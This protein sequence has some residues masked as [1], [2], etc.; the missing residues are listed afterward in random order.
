MAKA[1]LNANVDGGMDGGRESK[2]L[3]PDVCELELH[4]FEQGRVIMLLEEAAELKAR[5]AD[6][7]EDDEYDPK[8]HIARRW[9]EIREELAEIQAAEGQ[10]FGLRHGRVLFRVVLANGRRTLDGKMLVQNLL[11]AGM[12]ADVVN[13]V[14]EESTKTGADTYRREIK[15]LD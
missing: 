15:L 11:A 14:I 7:V 9:D 8:F 12:K 6:K 13:R 1:K 4:S 2:P 3:P 5:L 10:E